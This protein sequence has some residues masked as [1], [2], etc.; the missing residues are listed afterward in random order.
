MPKHTIDLNRQKNNGCKHCDKE[1]RKANLEAAL[2]NQTSSNL[3][4]MEIRCVGEW[5]YDKIYRLVQY[6]G[7]FTE[8][9][10]NKHSKL[11]YIEICS[12]PGRCLQRDDDFEIDGTPLA[13]INHPSF[14]HLNKATFIDINP[15]VIATLNQRI[16][17]KSAQ[18]KAFAHLGNYTIPESI[19][20]AIGPTDSNTL[21]LCFIDPTDCGIPFNT[22]KIIANHLK[23]VDFIIN[24]ALGTDFHRNS[25]NAILDPNFEKIRTKYQNFL[26]DTTFFTD[27]HNIEL[28][29]QDNIDEI[30]RQFIKKYIEQF[31][32][33]GFKFH[34]RQ[35]V[36]QFYELV[37]FSSNPLGLDFWKKACK[38][39]PTGQKELF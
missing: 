8:G 15:K 17:S 30:K 19:I 9:M 6:F 24:A 16:I 14:K 27:P 22:I 18:H 29:K 32:K 38:H 28:A 35:S 37:F 39:T 21:N 5:A 36:R 20:K 11:N 7:I 26:G 10:K 2:C 25:K 23:K 33:I 12:G 34:D 3:D 31:S 13:I 4:G 1:Y